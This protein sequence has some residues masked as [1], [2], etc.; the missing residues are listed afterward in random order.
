MTFIDG[1]VLT[2]AQLNTHMRDNFLETV[3]AKSSNNGGAGGGYFAV[4]G[5]FSLAE[6]GVVY[7]EIPGAETTTSH[8][9]ED[10]PLA[11]P[12]VSAITSTVA[13]LFMSVELSSTKGG[14][15][16]SAAVAVTGR[17][18]KPADEGQ[19]LSHSSGVNSRVQLGQFIYFDDLTPGFNTFTMKYSTTGDTATF[20]NRRLI[21]L[22]F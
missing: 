8:Q 18:I 9:Y 19:A 15:G 22:P 6:R 3:P 5:K 10:L 17:T 21:L 11:G 4:T 13:L 7:Q 2:A 1:A 14:N 12:T 20:R 16:C